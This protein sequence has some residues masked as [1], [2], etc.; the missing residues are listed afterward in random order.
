MT[1]DQNR[2]MK[3]V[4]AGQKKIWHMKRAERQAEHLK[5]IENR[6]MIFLAF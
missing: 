1:A 4:L 3:L 2:K 5:L 6:Y